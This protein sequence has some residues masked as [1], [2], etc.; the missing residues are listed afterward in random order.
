MVI[1]RIAPAPQPLT[2]VVGRIT[3]AAVPE[4]AAVATERQRQLRGAGAASGAAFSVLALIAFLLALGPDETTGL[5]ILDY[6]VEHDAAVKWQAALFGISAVLFLWFFAT[7]ARTVRVA[8][9]ASTTAYA[10][11]MVAA[12]GAAVALYFVGVGCWLALANSFGDAPGIAG[13]EPFAIGDAVVFWSVSDAAFT[14]SNFPAAA[15]LLAAAL[16]FLETRLLPE[17]SAVAGAG[18]AVFLLVQGFFQVV[19]D[20]DVL[21][22]LGIVAFL[23]FLAWV[24]LASALL[25][26]N[27]IREGGTVRSP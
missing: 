23:A 2:C 9:A 21:D 4:G 12:A 15:L 13:A 1:Q 25:T 5:A 18:V 17:W 16:A 20:A 3:I 14:L 11:I 19:S 10:A 24:F 26:R 7:L 8:A 27:V 6:Y 22:A